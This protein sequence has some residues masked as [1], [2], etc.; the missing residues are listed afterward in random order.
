MQFIVAER[1]K[2]RQQPP[3]HASLVVGHPSP[4]GLGQ[5]QDAGPAV[6]GVGHGLWARRTSRGSWLDVSST[7]SNG[8]RRSAATLRP[9][10]TTWARTSP[11]HP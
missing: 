11:T 10:A 8:V 7:P 3:D 5:P 9:S 6:T 4:F 1:V 2:L